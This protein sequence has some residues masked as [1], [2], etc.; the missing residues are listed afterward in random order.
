M[1][2]SRGSS[3]PRDSTCISYVSCIGRQILYPEHHLG[4]P[5]IRRL[6]E[7]ESAQIWSKL[8]RYISYYFMGVRVLSVATADVLSF[9]FEIVKETNFNGEA[10]QSEGDSLGLYHVW[11]KEYY[12][13]YLIF[14][15]VIICVPHLSF[16][17]LFLFRLHCAGSNFLWKIKLPLIHL[18]EGFS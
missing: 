16:Y 7:G 11:E 17:I 1:L 4:S 10:R 6:E 9:Q 18:T 8:P 2:S 13:K 15:M 5:R 3:W 14:F 12:L